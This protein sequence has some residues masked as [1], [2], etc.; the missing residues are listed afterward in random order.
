MTN[1]LRWAS[2]IVDRFEERG[3]YVPG[4]D[5]ASPRAGRYAGWVATGWLC[6]AGLITVVF[7][8]AR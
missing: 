8:F 5:D 3:V 1:P 2:R 6:A 7:L 4:D